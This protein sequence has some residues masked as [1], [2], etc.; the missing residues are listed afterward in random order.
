[1]K[2]LFLC[3]KYMQLYKGASTRGGVLDKM[4]FVVKMYRKGG[5]FTTGYLKEGGCF[6]EVL[7]WVRLDTFFNVL[8]TR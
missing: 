1:M 6:I 5:L 4:I 3:F 8:F 7:R 2:E